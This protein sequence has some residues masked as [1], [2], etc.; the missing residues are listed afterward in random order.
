M[1]QL[2][3]KLFL[4]FGGLLLIILAIGLQSIVRLTELGQSIDVIL[5]EN[6]RSVIACQQMKESLERIDSGLLFVLLGRTDEG[7][8]LVKEN[9]PLFEKAL[10]VELDNITL[11][12]EEEKAFRIRQLFGEYKLTARIILDPGAR[13][14]VRARTYFDKQF[15]IFNELKA[16]ADQILDMNQA[17][18]SNADLRARKTSASA[19][20]QMYIMLVAGITLALVFMLFINRWILR[21]IHRLTRS[22][23][24]VRGGN[25]ELVL[26]VESKDEI[27]RLSEAFNEM[28][29]SLR[30]FRRSDRAKLLRVQKATQAAFNSLPDAIAVVNLDGQVEVATGSAKDVFGLKPNLP[31][32]MLPDRWI[33]DLHRNAINSGRLVD[34]QGEQ[35]IIQRFVKGEERYFRPQGVPILDDEGYSAGVALLI[36]DITLLRQQDEMK[37]GV[38][39]TV[40]HQLKTPLTSLRMAIHLLLDEQVGDLSAKQAELLLVARDD[41]DR[42][43]RIIDDLLDISRIE[44]GR[45]L[46]DMAIVAPE[47]IIREAIEPFRRVNQDK[48]IRLNLEIPDDLPDVRADGMQIGHV[49]SNLLSNALKYTS[50]GGIITISTTSDD[51]WVHFSV[52]DTGKGIPEA[53]IGHVFEKFLSVPGEKAQQGTGLGLSIAKEIV[54]AHGGTVGVDSV[55]GKGSTFTFTLKR[56]DVNNR[57]YEEEV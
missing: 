30:E 47:S 20:R 23:E 55:E 56:A 27:G 12:G 44:A 9:I 31:I 38:I 53:Y 16:T 45:V 6:F 4:G 17:N 42:L 36:Q 2:R 43:T 3:H 19:K 33:A 40:S 25:L 41:S 50:P 49:I 1:W 14:D 28:A 57:E 15:P 48:G 37:R 11:P 10:Q 32:A 46:M 34:L 5:R 22:V 13:P 29:K 52:T 35:S 24:D 8:R 18:M 26:P 51:E 21:P 39:S 54:E 7:T